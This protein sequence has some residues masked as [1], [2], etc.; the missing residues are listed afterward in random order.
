[1]RSTLGSCSAHLSG[2]NVRLLNSP[3]DG[4]SRGG[5][6]CDA[7]AIGPDY[8]A[9]SIGDVSGH[10]EAVADTM[11]VVRSAVAGSI[12]EGFTPSTALCTANTVAHD[13]GD[14]AIATA[15][16]GAFNRRL[17]TLTFSNAGHPPPLIVTATGEGFLSPPVGDLPLGIFRKYRSADY[18]VAVPEG[19]LIVFYTDGV[20][21]HR[22]DIL[23]GEQELVEI[24]RDVRGLAVPDAAQEIAH[25]IFKNGRG[26]DDA[27]I[28][29]LRCECDR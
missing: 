13:W 16:V 2:W 21:E 8:V 12:Y 25:R 22:L 9:I 23:R 5:D 28:L 3:A 15:A 6:W 11:N 19:A 18:V 1:M 10:G 27:A 29:T 24:C 14:G 4:A 20:V 26:R 7:F 17:H